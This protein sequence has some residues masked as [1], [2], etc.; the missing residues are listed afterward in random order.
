MDTFKRDNFQRLYPGRPFPG[1]E[2]MG[3]EAADSVRAQLAIR[4]GGGPSQAP[5]D[6]VRDIA[7]EGEL[8]QGEDAKEGLDVLG[9]LDGLGLEHT[10]HAYLN[11]GR[12]EKLD[13]IRLRDLSEYFEDLWYPDSDDLD[14]ID[15]ECKWILSVRHDGAVSIVRL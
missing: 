8:L 2:V 6:L 13:R 10:E 1:V 3:E 12:F 7:E 11:W 4:L 5:A 15:T 9:V 14:I